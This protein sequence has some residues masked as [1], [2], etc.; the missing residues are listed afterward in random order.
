MSKI[1]YCWIDWC[2]VMPIWSAPGLSPEKSTATR[3]LDDPIILRLLPSMESNRWPIDFADFLFQQH[4]LY[5]APKR[6]RSVRNNVKRHFRRV[7][8][9]HRLPTQLGTTMFHF[10]ILGKGASFRQIPG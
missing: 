9:G 2:E 1:T 8:V 10:V 7:F 4:Q 6:G 5:A 3:A